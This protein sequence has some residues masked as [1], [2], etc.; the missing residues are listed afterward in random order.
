MRPWPLPA[1]TPHLSR[2]LPDVTASPW[3]QPAVPHP[4]MR[5]LSVQE[6]SGSWQLPCPRDCVCVPELL[7]AERKKY[8]WKGKQTAPGM[9]APRFHGDAGCGRG[10][11][12]QAAVSNQGRA[13]AV[14][15]SLGREH[16]K[17][18]GPRPWWLGSPALGRSFSSPWSSQRV[19]EG[20]GGASAFLCPACGGSVPPNANP[21]PPPWQPP[22]YFLLPRLTL[23]VPHMCGIL[24][25]LSFMIDLLS[26]GSLG[27]IR[28]GACVFGGVF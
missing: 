13:F 21:R 19:W 4:S 18:L 12:D 24:L 16:T 2:G 28:V 22:A 6:K 14:A 3:Q 9:A 27:F 7:T 10:P 11:L 5:G 15:Q 17:C 25:D 26:P 8:T 23:Q 20:G 1:C